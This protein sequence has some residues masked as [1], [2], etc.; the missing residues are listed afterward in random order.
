MQGITLVQGRPSDYTQAIGDEICERIAAGQSL[1][2]ICS[3]EHLPTLQTLSTWA[4][5][6]VKSVAATSFPEAYARARSLA[7]DR[8]AEEIKDISDD[9]RNDW[10]D[11]QFGEQSV[12]CVDHEHVT[13]SKLRVDTR[14]FLLSKLRPEIYGDRLAHQMLDEH[15]KPAR[16]GVV[17][18]VDGAAGRSLPGSE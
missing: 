6:E 14:K 15:G 4:N 2:E 3:F 9:A 16:A 8:M 11:R 5:G 18:V 10:M 13:R 12:R 17:I 1:T 7:I